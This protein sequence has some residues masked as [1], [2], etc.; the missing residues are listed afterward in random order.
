MDE[1]LHDEILETIE[2]II[3]NEEIPSASYLVRTVSDRCG[4]SMDDVIDVMHLNASAPDAVLQIVSHGDG[5]YE[6]GISEDILE[7]FEFEEG[8]P[9]SECVALSGI[10]ALSTGLASVARGLLNE[11]YT[12]AEVCD[13]LS[14][15]LT[16]ALA[17]SEIIADV[18]IVPD[19]DVMITSGG[20][21]LSF[22]S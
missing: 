8:M 7:D 2:D 15:E 6:V 19:E 11:G 21:I 1:R 20:N 5:E 16:A 9:E 12:E 18:S 22:P 10:T 13:V 14:E 4:C 17:G 3:E